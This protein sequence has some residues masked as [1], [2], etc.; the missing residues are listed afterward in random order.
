MNIFKNYFSN[1]IER[2]A[3][4]F[5]S[6]N[7]YGEIYV[8]FPSGIVRNFIGNLQGHKADIKFNNYKLIYKLFKNGSIGF[9]ESYMDGDFETQNLS[10]LLLFAHQNELS[11]LNKKK[12]NFVNNFSIKLHH[13]LNKN[14]KKGSK[15]NIYHH[16]DLGNNFYK[17]WLDESMTYSSALFKNKTDDLNKA[18]I[19]KYSEIV[20]QLKL[21][22]NSKLLEIGCGWGGFSTFVAKNYGSK[23]KA[24]TISKQQYEFTANKIFKEGLNDRVTLE[25][26]DY[27]DVKEKF[28][29]IVSIEMFEAV[30]KE[31]W[32]TYFDKL[33]NSL[34]DNGLASLQIITIKDE[35]V[36]YYQNNP[37]FIQQYIFPGGV[38]PSKNQIKKITNQIGLKCNEFKSFGQS[39]AKTLKLWNNQ[40]QL[41]WE[42]LSTM[43]FNLRF[44]RMW[45]YYLSYCEAG[46][47]NGST[48]VSHFLLNK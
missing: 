30:G 19:N 16:Y 40:F 44:K 5:L 36:D 38:L 48:D 42:E 1:S 41:S 4:N 10:N 45:E 15:K 46:F 3:I 33:K 8:T 28:S 43:G 39:Y 24:I 7:N 20:D 47:T 18:Q 11:Y 26:C 12:A 31:Y 6:R 9:A 13:Y 27:R 14:T 35:K 37:D 34:S 22:D 32:R 2:L 25:M 21:N 17:Y 23:V 29:H